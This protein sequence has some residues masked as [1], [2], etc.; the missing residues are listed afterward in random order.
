M[1]TASP[2]T[3]LA[4]RLYVS[5]YGC[6]PLAS[7]QKYK[8]PRAKRS[9]ALVKRARGGPFV[10]SPSSFKMI[11]SDSDPVDDVVLPEDEHDMTG[12]K[13]SFSL[14]CPWMISGARQPN[15]PARLF[16]VGAKDDWP[17]SSRRARPKSDTSMRKEPSLAL[18]TSTF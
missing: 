5:P 9:T 12:S 11:K 18:D 8:H 7:I 13:P 10:F 1:L 15:D 6:S 2:L 17:C 16:A 3:M 4:S 14:T